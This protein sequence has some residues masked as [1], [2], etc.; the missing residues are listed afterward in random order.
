MPTEE[1]QNSQTSGDT[2]PVGQNDP[3]NQDLNLDINLNLDWLNLSGV[4][5][6]WD[7]KD[8]SNKK[9]Q[10]LVVEESISEKPKEKTDIQEE[11]ILENKENK[12]DEINIEDTKSVNID[13]RL[14]VNQLEDLDL[15]NVWVVSKELKKQ[16]VIKEENSEI[17]DV[18]ND[19]ESKDDDWLL[20]EDKK[21]E[22]LEKWIEINWI[23]QWE[24]NPDNEVEDEIVDKTV[25]KTLEKWNTDV[26]LENLDIPFVETSKTDEVKDEVKNINTNDFKEEWPEDLEAPEEFHIE[27]LWTDIVENNDWDIVSDTWDLNGNKDVYVPN[28]HDFNELSSAL[29]WAKS[30]DKIN[31]KKT[32]T[33]IESDSKDVISQPQ[34]DN[35]QILQNN[36]KKE[37]TNKTMFSGVDLDSLISEVDGIKPVVKLTENNKIKTQDN[38]ILDMNNSSETLQQKN[39]GNILVESKIKNDNIKEDKSKWIISNAVKTEEQKFNFNNLTKDKL[40]KTVASIPVV[41]NVVNTPQ[42]Q[43]SV[44]V[45]TEPVI[46]P[47]PVVWS[48]VVVSSTPT[49]SNIS[50]QWE[51]PV[52]SNIW[53]PVPVTN[54]VQAGVM[55]VWVPTW[56]VIM[57]AP[58][59]QWK[60]KHKWLKI[61]GLIIILL[62]LWFFILSKMYPE[63]MGN[64]MWKDSVD[65]SVVESLEKNIVEETV[66]TEDVIH[67]AA[68]DK[69]NEEENTWLSWNVEDNQQMKDIINDSMSGDYAWVDMMDEELI[70]DWN[71]EKDIMTWNNIQTQDMDPDSLAAQIENDNLVSSWIEDV[72]AEDVLSGE[73]MKHNASEEPFDA[74]EEIEGVIDSSSDNNDELLAKLQEY[75]DKWNKYDNWGRENNNTTAIKYGLYISRNAEELVVN[76]ENG[77]EI[78]TTKLDDYFAQFDKYLE[79]LDGLRLSVDWSGKSEVL[80]DETINESESISQ[81]EEESVSTPETED[82]GSTG[83]VQ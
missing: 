41:N 69:S 40:K 20:E 47:V 51:A 74:F 61:F 44:G 5:N 80:V 24:N 66:S 37:K 78:I 17:Q 79:K 9:P 77:E 46:S 65:N 73:K 8:L 27:N 50:A 59:A 1:N 13:D 48:N 49:I 76:I 4:E 11:K 56:A 36:I 33:N 54:T 52:V 82:G 23:T 18:Q 21:V 83:T 67:D 12:L 7:K 39:Q 22:E 29:E 10:N 68:I 16:D 42:L 35:N 57:W 45:K 19:I 58:P 25:K 15:S 3:V 72:I 63:E 14:D 26:D 32:W 70:D 71:M 75:Q 60:S 30:G 2:N 55:P 81:W 34:L 64:I 6:T 38:V 28:E 62:W 43:Q 31:L 53:Q